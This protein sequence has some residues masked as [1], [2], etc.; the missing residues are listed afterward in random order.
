MPL[1]MFTHQKTSDIVLLTFNYNC[2]IQLVAADRHRRIE[3]EGRTQRIIMTR[4]YKKKRLMKFRQPLRKLIHPTLLPFSFIDSHANA[5]T[6][7]RTH[8]WLNKKHANSFIKSLYII[9]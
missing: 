2:M 8:T 7:A 5:H 6:H 4:I 9:N 3:D 1:R